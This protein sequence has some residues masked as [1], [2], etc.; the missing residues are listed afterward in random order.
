MFLEKYQ[1]MFQSLVEVKYF[2]LL[3]LVLNLST[4]SQNEKQIHENPEAKMDSVAVLLQGSSKGLISGTF[5]SSFTQDT[6]NP[7]RIILAKIETGDSLNGLPKWKVD[8]AFSLCSRMSPKIEFITERE[9][10]TFR[11]KYLISEEA[12]SNFM[13]YYDSLEADYAAILRI[14]KIENIL[15]VNLTLQSAI[16]SLPVLN[17]QGWAEIRYKESETGKDVIDPTLLQGLQRAVARA[18]GDSLY[19]EDLD[20]SLRV[21][22]HSTIVVGGLKYIN[23]DKLKP[24]RL[25]DDEIPSA[26][27]AVETMYEELR[28]SGK[29]V[30]YDIATRD[31]L[32]SLNKMYGVEN[33]DAPTRFEIKV[34]YD[35]KVQYYITGEFEHLPEGGRLKIYFCRIDQN[36]INIINKVEEILKEDDNVEYRKLLRKMISKLIKDYH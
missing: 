14:N 36:G 20:S 33:Y 17:G 21:F 8:A 28:S 3:L 30:C 9:K 10:R 16:D 15:G 26:Y 2:I 13:L 19:W 4:F 6:I 32:Y 24:W 5:S 23:N 1:N 35:F 7:I 18:F 31:S 27:D 12:G 25:F 22:P 11:E 29:F 34:L